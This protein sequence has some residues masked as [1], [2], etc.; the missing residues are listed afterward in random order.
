[1]LTEGSLAA[2]NIGKLLKEIEGLPKE[3]QEKDLTIEEW[4]QREEF[5]DDEDDE[6]DNED[7]EVLC[8]DNKAAT[9]ILLQ[10]SGSWRTRHLRVRASALKQRILKGNQKVLHIPG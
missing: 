5:N 8:V 7:Y 6:E 3:Y 1:M 4:E 10:E 9:Q 2:K